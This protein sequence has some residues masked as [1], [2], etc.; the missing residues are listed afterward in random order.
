[1]EFTTACLIARKELPTK[2]NLF[3]DY[4]NLVGHFC[5]KVIITISY[6][7]YMGT[8]ALPE[9]CVIYTR[10]RSVPVV[11]MLGSYAVKD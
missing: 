5:P 2:I 10:L 8:Q 6:G 1:M 4:E 7:I 11:L 9:E 3:L